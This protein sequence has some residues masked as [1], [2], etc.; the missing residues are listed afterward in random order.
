[1]WEPHIRKF[2]SHLGGTGGFSNLVV[3][4]HTDLPRGGD[5]PERF[6]N[7]Q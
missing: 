4:N 5:F 2:L 1:V 3:Y 6:V 7:G